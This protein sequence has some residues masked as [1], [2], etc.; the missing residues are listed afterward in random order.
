VSFNTVAYPLGKPGGLA[1]VC[2]TLPAALARAGV[3]VSIMLPDYRSALDGAV[4]KQ[5]LGALAGSGR[6]LLARM[7]DSA[8]PVYLFD[9]AD[10]L[11]G[12]P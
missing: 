9:H 10:L 5:Q 3:D 8:L 4:G 7:P 12:D 11:L 6:L 1:D 2:A